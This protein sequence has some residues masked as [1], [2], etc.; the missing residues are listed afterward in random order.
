MVSIL[1]SLIVWLGG[2]VLVMLLAIIF[3]VLVERLI[4]HILSMRE[5]LGLLVTFAYYHDDFMRWVSAQQMAGLAPS[6]EVSPPDEP[7]G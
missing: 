4:A 5:L 1:E 2:S 3:M 7:K 6:S